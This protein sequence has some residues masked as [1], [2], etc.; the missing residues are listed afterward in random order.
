MLRELRIRNFAIIE[1]LA[2]TFQQG[3][4]VITGETGAG[5]SIILQALALV[6]GGRA[7]ADVVRTGQAEASIEALFETVLPQVI[8][9]DFGLDARATDELLVRRQISSNG[10]GRIR[11]NGGPATVAMLGRLGDHLVH[12]Y[13]Q[14]DQ[15]LLLRP[16]S[17]L[18]FLDRFGSLGTERARM[19]DAYQAWATARQA[20]EES[21]ALR[22]TA[23]ERRELLAFQVVELEGAGLREDEEEELRRERTLIRS[24]ERIHRICQEGEDTLYSRQSSVVNNLARLAA[25]L[26]EIKDV[27]PDLGTSAEL[28]ETARIQ[29]E[30]AALG[31]RAQAARVQFEPNRLEELEERLA[32]LIELGRKFRVPSGELPS[33]LQQL[34][35]ELEQIQNAA[36]A[37]EAAAKAAARF[38]REARAIARDL[39]AR[40]AKTAGKLEK[41]LAKELA[42]LGMPEAVFR[43]ARPER[44]ASA[45][46]T[47]AE[48]GIDELEFQLSANPGEAPRRLA[49]DASG[50]ELSRIML[51]LEALTA[52]ANDTP[53]LIFDEVDAGIG[54]AVADAVGRRLKKIASSRQLLCITHLPQ[55]AAYADHHYAVAK[56]SH[57]D[58][59]MAEAQLL[60]PSERV[61]EL[62]RMLGGGI[63]PDEAERYARRLIEQGQRPTKVA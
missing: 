50:G 55:I 15:A 57:D 52:A 23:E 25:Q 5:K 43:V 4:N 37:H 63:A 11:M 40:R 51:A 44:T 41:R 59:T 38:E 56:R 6:A 29:L 18:D 35:S 39:S 31:L 54:G 16:A 12:I 32:A 7:Q 53:I 2:L 46:A 13:G 62:S 36:P 3:F 9:D 24:A 60:G 17:H 10:K 30:E 1:D 14:H 8:L 27:V 58:R 21:A 48:S 34:R 26:A 33:V 20:L 28:V 61:H 19:R 22:A 49:R 45:A 42:E 47:L